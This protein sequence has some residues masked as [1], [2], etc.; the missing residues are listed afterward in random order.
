MK[1]LDMRL[2][3]PGLWSVLYILSIGCPGDMNRLPVQGNNTD[4]DDLDGGIW[5]TDSNIGF[6]SNNDKNTHQ[7][8]DSGRKIVG[9]SRLSMDV[10]PEINTTQEDGCYLL[11]PVCTDHPEYGR[12]EKFLDVVCRDKGKGNDLDC[13]RSRAA[14]VAFW[15]GN[16]K[17]PQ[18]F[19][20]TTATLE[21]GGK[22][23]GQKMYQTGDACLVCFNNCPSDQVFWQMLPKESNG[24][25]CTH[26][27]LGYI[28]PRES[29]KNRSYC[30]ERVYDYFEYCK[31]GTTKFWT[32]GG[33]YQGWVMPKGAD[34][35]DE[36]VY[37]EIN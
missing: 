14:E 1:L 30:Y 7:S 3:A 6:S 21:I 5:S 29:D 4:N 19:P 31:K 33:F 18:P 12:P 32:W 8:T 16:D 17:L 36:A 34:G 37:Y 35:N 11:N 23:V 24:S 20:Q 13:C 27:Y 28:N 2:F 22:I 15:C 10:A 25:G 9:D 26:D